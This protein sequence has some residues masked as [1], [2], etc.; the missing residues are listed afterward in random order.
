[1]SSK[2]VSSVDN[3]N[4]AQG[5]DVHLEEIERQN[6]AGGGIEQDVQQVNAVPSIDRATLLK[7]ICAGYSFF[8]AGIN[9]GSLGPLIP[10]LL[11]SYS[12]NTNFV[13]IV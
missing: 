3:S 10:Y 5:P 13:S 9:D 8:C 6:P 12:I 11:R 4:A 1:M 7:L 2:P